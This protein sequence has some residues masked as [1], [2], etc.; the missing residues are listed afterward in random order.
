MWKDLS[1]QIFEILWADYVDK[2]S[3]IYPNYQLTVNDVFWE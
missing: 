2:Y 3:N 1:E